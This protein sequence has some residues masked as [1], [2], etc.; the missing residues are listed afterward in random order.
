MG[1]RLDATGSK[2]RDMTLA[3]EPEVRIGSSK[4]IA[5]LL[6]VGIVTVR[7]A[8]RVLEHEVLLSVRRG[9][10]GGY[11]G[12]RPD[13]AVPERSFG[14][15]LKCM[16]GLAIQNYVHIFDRPRLPAGLCALGQAISSRGVDLQNALLTTPP[17]TRKA[18]P[19]IA[20]ASGLAT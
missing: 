20:D 16:G 17:S 12:T 10:G 7:Q 1:A 4:E 5:R 11:Y 15:F 18:A 2:L 13:E 3:R 9:P 19:V 8:A 6:S 14:T